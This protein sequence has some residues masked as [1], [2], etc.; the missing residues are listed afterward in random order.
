MCFLDCSG[1]APQP[2]TLAL[3]GHLISSF[4][5]LAEFRRAPRAAS[6]PQVP[7]VPQVPEVFIRIQKQ[8]QQ[9][10]YNRYKS[11]LAFALSTRIVHPMGRKSAG[12]IIQRKRM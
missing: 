8:K 12:Q 7:Q 3:G 6:M 10:R 5:P 9:Y 4:V 1:S 2:L 11:R